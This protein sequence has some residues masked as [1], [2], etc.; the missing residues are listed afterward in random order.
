MIVSRTYNENYY[1]NRKKIIEDFIQ[2]E[3]E[4]YF[5]YIEEVESLVSSLKL[6]IKTMVS[7]EECNYEGI[8]KRLDLINLSLE[9]EIDLIEKDINTCSITEKETKVLFDKMC[10]EEEKER[11]CF[12]DMLSKLK[13]EMELKEF[14]IQNMEKLYV[15][16]ESMIKENIIYNNDYIFTIEQF[17]QFVSK[18]ERILVEYKNLQKEKTV[19]EQRI[20]ELIKENI[21]LR[22]QNESFDFHQVANVLE[23]LSRIDKTYSLT[24]KSLEDK[25]K[26]LSCENDQISQCLEKILKKHEKLSDENDKLNQQL[27]STFAHTKNSS[28]K[29]FSDEKYHDN[30]ST[31]YH[32]TSSITTIRTMQAKNVRSTHI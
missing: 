9:E 31:F 10:Q 11:L 6:T 1:Q 7:D 20:N 24:L 21:N 2:K 12:L 5:E 17:S 32:N 13:R 18:N 26:E 22:S 28:T 29:S 16:I 27:I 14:K 25:F 15:E 19:L 30:Y 4:N 23:E 3:N 8:T